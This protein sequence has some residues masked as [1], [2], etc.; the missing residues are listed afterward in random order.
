MRHGWTI[1]GMVLVA[2]W[3]V[4]GGLGA[5]WVARRPA[6]GEMARDLRQGRAARAAAGTVD[7]IYQVP[8]DDGKGGTASREVRI[9]YRSPKQ[10]RVDWRGPEPFTAVQEEEGLRLYFPNWRLLLWMPLGEEVMMSPV[11]LLGDPDEYPGAPGRALTELLADLPGP[12]VRGGK[13]TQVRSGVAIPA[14]TF[15]LS[16]PE[17]TRVIKGPIRWW[18]QASEIHAAFGAGPDP[19]PSD[20]PILGQE[21]PVR[22]LWPRSLPKGYGRLTERGFAPPHEEGVEV[23]ALFANPSGE[24]VLFWQGKE[25]Y[26]R[27]E[28]YCPHRQPVA[29]AV[30]MKGQFARTWQYDGAPYP[31]RAL[32]WKQD[33]V[34]CSVEATALSEG[35]LQR[36]AESVAWVT[37]AGERRSRT[38]NRE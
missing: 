22:V 34:H 14:A 9:R 21:G 19:T 24:T 5:V 23:E 17:G 28:E 11:D 6:V 35:E 30:W 8:E 32:L 2:L 33:G 7:I 31:R 38:G 16:V 20:R 13:G 3:G 25:S 36:I 15:R 26:M 29:R 10:S 18:E 12:R 4:G 27:P 1:I 37:V